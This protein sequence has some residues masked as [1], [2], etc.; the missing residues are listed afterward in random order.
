MTSAKIRIAPMTDEEMSPEQKEALEPYRTNGTIHNVYR[1]FGRDFGMFK[2][3]QSFGA[4]TMLKSNLPARDREIAILRI[5]WL[6]RSVYE[7]GHHAYMAERA[8]LTK[9]EVRRVIDGAEAS[10][11]TDWEKSIILATDQIKLD[12][13]M[14]D[15]VYDALAVKYDANQIIDLIMTVGNYNMVSTG[16]NIL[17]VPLEEGIAGWPEGVEP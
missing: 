11:W 6:N 10:G 8:G 14:S 7:W 9:E 15:I 12:A 3:Y 13:Q 16:L 2:R 1:V 5:A 17:G 4:Y